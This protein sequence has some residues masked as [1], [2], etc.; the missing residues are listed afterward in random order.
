MIK[1]IGLQNFRS[2]T[3][4][5][6]IELKPIT[7]FVGKNSSGK[8][9]LLRTFPLLRQ[10]VE[11]NTTGPILWYGRYV[12]FGDFTDVLSRNSEKKE[13]TFSFSLSTPPELLQ[14]Y[15]YYRLTSKNIQAMDIEVELTVYSKDKKTKTKTIKITLSNA[16][17]F[18][19]MDENNSN[20]KL[21]IE[22]NNKKIERDGI[23]AKNLGQFIPNLSL[24]GKEENINSTTSFFLRHSRN[25]K[26][27]ELSFIDL[28]VKYIKPYFHTKS[29]I[30]Q[31]MDSFKRIA[32]MPKDDAESLIT[33][34]FREQK[35]FSKNFQF[36]HDDIMNELYPHVV[37][38]NIN[39]IIDII[40]TCLSNLFRG[41]KYIAPLRA[42]SERFYRF[43]DLQVNEIDH[44]GS[45]LAMLLNSLKPTDKSKF[46]AWTKLNFDFIIK[47][48]QSGSHFAILINT[49]ENSENYNVSDMGFGYSQVL[50]IVTAIWLETERRTTSYRNPITFII[51]QPELHLHPSYQN[52]L[53]RIFAKVITKAK[54][55]NVDLKIIFETH[56]QTM[57]EALGEYIEE[58]EGLLEDDISILV[59]EKNEA[60][61]TIVKNSYFDENG[62]LQNWPVG[63]FSGK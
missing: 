2:F 56:S 57:I 23:I 16:T 33:F 9:S 49:G 8:S 28:A 42:T 22:S 50:P 61:Q 1:G 46:E 25:D 59:F 17:I 21:F 26:A 24:K 10:S 53:A 45:N 38:W 36:Q 48:E 41:V 11:E 34:L 20:V 14:R 4:K 58:N 29:D 37:G 19:T 15:S 51:E 52:N 5:T 12:D 55:N 47:V 6:F 35:T 27:L 44:T 54:E 13:I 40:N 39:N 63:F 60:Q 30:N 7:V 3:N 31:I 32:F 62:F 43:Q 18:I